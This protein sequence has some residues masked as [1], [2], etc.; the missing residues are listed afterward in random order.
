MTGDVSKQPEGHG[1]QERDEQHGEVPGGRVVLRRVLPVPG[2]A[3]PL[4]GVAHAMARA[5]APDG[6]GVG[7]RIGQQVQ[8]SEEAVA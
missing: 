2:Y 8:G 3:V 7:R 1:A 6:G 4:R 5:M